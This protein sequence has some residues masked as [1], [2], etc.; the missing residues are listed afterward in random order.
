MEDKAKLREGDSPRARFYRHKDEVFGSQDAGMKALTARI[1]VDG[2]PGKGM[3]ERGGKAMDQLMPIFK[4]VKT[5]IEELNA[6]PD[7]ENLFTKGKETLDR[8]KKTQ[9]ELLPVP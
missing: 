8:L 5:V 3:T 1:Y 6:N 4:E 7:D 9:D 2:D